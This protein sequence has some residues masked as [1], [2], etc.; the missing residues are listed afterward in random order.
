MFNGV[1]EYAGGGSRG[2]IM[3]Y[4]HATGTLQSVPLICNKLPSVPQALLRHLLYV[5][6]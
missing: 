4:R 2:E 6:T 5:S 1:Q 3:W